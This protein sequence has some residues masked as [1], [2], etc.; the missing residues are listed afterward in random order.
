MSIKLPLLSFVIYLFVILLPMRFET[1]GNTYA[2]TID[3]GE[4]VIEAL[5]HFCTEHNIQ[6]AHFTAIGAVEFVSCGYYDLI[7]KGYVF[8]SYPELLEVVS[9]TGNVILK[10]NTPFV[11]I[12][13]VFTDISNNAFGG[14]VEKMRVGVTLEVLLTVL[15]FTLSR[16]FNSEIGLFL[17]HCNNPHLLPAKEEDGPKEETLGDIFRLR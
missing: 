8:K 4:E 3:Q 15:P 10:D 17:I 12:H 5:T 13:A 14:H 16:T 6:N 1:S 9:A 2:I 7:D 11:H